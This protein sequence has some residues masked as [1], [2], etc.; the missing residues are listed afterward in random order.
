MD[1]DKRPL[2]DEFDRAT[3]YR[4]PDPEDDGEEYELAPP[5]EELVEAER[6]RA[7]EAVEQAQLAVDMQQLERDES[8]FGQHQMDDYLENLKK[9]KFQFTTRHWLIAT[10]IVAL[11]LVI[12]M[13][14]GPFGVAVLTIFIL[15]AGA[16]GYITRR[17]ARQRA[18]LDARRQELYQ[19][20][21]QQEQTPTPPHQ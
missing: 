17:E 1:A 7:R 9:V 4:A 6:R 2:E 3:F 5:D 11:A 10:A 18:E 12:G 21:R 14:I 8:T 20:K 16:Y 13:V 19:R 15:L